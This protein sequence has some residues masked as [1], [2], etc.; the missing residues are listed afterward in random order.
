[1]IAGA[2]TPYVWSFQPGLTLSLLIVGGVYWWRFG[3]LRRSRGGV[4]RSDYLRAASFAAGLVVVALALMSPIDHLGETRLFSI[5][6]L[7]HLMIF[8]FAP[9]LLLLGLSRPLLRPVV[10]RLRPLEQSLGYLAHPLVVLLLAG[11]IDLGLAPA[12]ALRQRAGQ[13][14]GAPA[15]ALHLLHGRAWRSG[16]T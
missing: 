11:R 5:H 2:E 3:E 6:M 14:L 10:R 7:Q 15:R 16:G 8:D 13:R 1:M 9:I 4:G 12:R